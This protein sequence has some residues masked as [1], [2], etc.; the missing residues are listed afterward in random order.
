MEQELETLQR[1]KRV[2]E[3]S[4]DAEEAVIGIEGVIDSRI[5]ILESHMDDEYHETKDHLDAKGDY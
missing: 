2:I 1:I 5:N 3:R 4:D